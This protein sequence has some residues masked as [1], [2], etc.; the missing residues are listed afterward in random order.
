MHCHSVMCALVLCAVTSATVVRK[1]SA[2]VNVHGD[3]KYNSSQ[4]HGTAATSKPSCASRTPLPDGEWCSVYSNINKMDPT[5]CN[6][7]YDANQERFC[8]FH[9]TGTHA[10]KCKPDGEECD[11]DAVLETPAWGGGAFT[12]TCMPIPRGSGTPCY[13]AKKSTTVVYSCP[14]GS[15]YGGVGIITD[16]N[17]GQTQCC[18]QC[19]NYNCDCHSW[20]EEHHGDMFKF[21]KLPTHMQTDHNNCCVEVNCGSNRCCPWLDQTER[22]KDE[23]KPMTKEEYGAA[24]GSYRDEEGNLVNS[25]GDGGTYVDE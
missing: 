6:R 3:V 15:I 7:Y 18:V 23:A 12:G 2:E 1:Q 10:G 25:G 8:Q 20:T 24:Y 16:I 11:V 21:I 9:M 5:N 13:Q 22:C 19:A 4:Q 14:A 17:V